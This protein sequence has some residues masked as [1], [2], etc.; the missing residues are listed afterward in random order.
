MATTHQFKTNSGASS[1]INRVN[2]AADTSGPKAL[3]TET[4]VPSITAGKAALYF[5]PDRVLVRDGNRFS[6][7]SYA[8]MNVRAGDTHFIESDVTPRDAPGRSNLEVRQRTR[9]PGPP[10]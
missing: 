2:A 9:W 1:I 8:H 5:L 7:I 10:I 6:D 4:V 3:S